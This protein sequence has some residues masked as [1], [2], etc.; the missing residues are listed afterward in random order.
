MSNVIHN[1]DMPQK[2]LNRN[3]HSAKRNKNDDF[4][5][6]LT[7][8]EK[9]LRHYKRHFR[10]KV[11]LC[12]CDDP[13]ISNFFHYFSH[14]F[15]HLGLKKLITTCYKNDQMDL[16]SQ[17][18]AERAIYL[19][20]NGDKNGN[21]IPD[22]KEIGIKELKGNGD[23]RSEECIKL[24]KQSDIVCTNPPFSLFREYINQLVE[25]EKKFLIIGNYNAV[26][27]KEIFPLIKENKMWLGV[28][29]DGRNIWFRIPD[30]YEKY[31]KI[32]DGVKYAFVAGVVWFT[33]LS[34]KKKN[35]ELILV[36]KYKGN[37]TE[38]PKYD[39]YNAIEVS[40]VVN[41]PKDYK[42]VMGVP[43]TFLNKYNPNQFEIVGSNRG[44]NQDPEGIY[45]RGSLINGKETFKRIF[46]K[47]RK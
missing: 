43:I 20:Y 35:E 8:I 22:P 19:E 13:C 41:I 37:E 9:E 27:Y 17:N 33:N 26:T 34:H 40:K 7:D 3:L 46:I 14:N 28:T 1:E 11:V 10:N 29:L 4:Y 24:L 44:R 47:R 21:R 12:N 32:E 36:K 15:E 5:T 31:H 30:W 25:Y 6:Q 2:S 39:N 38:Y 45:G 23:F 16:F 18:D 42:G